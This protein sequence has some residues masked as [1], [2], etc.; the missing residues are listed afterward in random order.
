MNNMINLLIKNKP[1]QCKACNGKLYYLKD[2]RYHCRKCGHETM[3]DLGKVK[4]FLKQNEDATVMFIA[5]STGVDSELIEMVL[6]EG[7]I[8]IPRDSNYYLSCEKCGC[9]IREGKFCSSCVYEITGDI[10]QLLKED[11]RKNLLINNPEMTGIMH[12]RRK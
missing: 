1:I 8:E 11:I 4:S 5:Q 2:G 7:E 6:R 12:I 9:S 10:K 3:D